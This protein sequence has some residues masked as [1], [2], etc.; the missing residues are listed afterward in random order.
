AH[1]GDLLLGRRARMTLRATAAVAA[2][3]G[4]A[5]VVAGTEGDHQ[6]ADAARARPAAELGGVIDDFSHGAAGWTTT[7]D[8]KLRTTTEGADYVLT[9]SGS[10]DPSGVTIS[11]PLPAGWTVSVDLRFSRHVK[12]NIELG[13]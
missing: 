9:M 3:V 6:S 2:A 5:F 4:I 12:G 8:P 13:G 7:R 10:H 1:H 11:R